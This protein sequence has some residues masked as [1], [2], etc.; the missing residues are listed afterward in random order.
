MSISRTAAVGAALIFVLPLCLTLRSFAQSAANT[1]C[2]ISGR[3]INRTT[4]D[5]VGNVSVKL[6]D[7][8]SLPDG[9]VSPWDGMV[10]N[11]GSSTTASSRYSVD[12][13]HDG[14]FCFA[15][16]APGQYRLFASKTGYLNSSYIED[17][18]IIEI[19]SGQEMLPPLSVN[20]APFSG[21]SGLVLDSAG[22][23]LMNVNMVAVKRSEIQGRV[24]LMPV[25][26]T[27]SSELG[28]FRIGKLVPGIYYVYAQP[29]PSGV[30]KSAVSLVRTYYPT[31]LTLAA[32][33]PITLGV[34]EEA[35]GVL[36]QVQ[37]AQIS[38]VVGRVLGPPDL[39]GGSTV[40]LHYADEDQLGILYGPNLSAE[41]MYDFPGVA[42]GRYL[43]TV[44]STRGGGHREVDVSSSDVTADVQ[45]VPNVTVSG[46]WV[47][48][49]TGAVGAAAMPRI[50]L[51]AADAVV[52]SSYVAA[53]YSDGTFS[54]PGVFPG[55]YFV[56]VSLANGTY[57]KQL[58]IG[59]K[60]SPTGE[61]DLTMGR[62]PE[63]K[64]EIAVGGSTLSGDITAM[65][66]AGA[67]SAPN[68]ARVVLMP[69]R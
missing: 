11:I 7:A 33:T 46:T 6:L 13:M 30:S 64:I 25:Q 21:I 55:R 19:S 50:D 51:T 58:R 53:V 31:S 15:A 62:S 60:E 45:F 32:S 35:S 42:P 61:V 43:L 63:I 39:W 40:N 34:G 26:G 2:A 48:Q 22:E 52:G 4:K 65:T 49:G 47:V 67:K 3:V 36:V 41:G 8:R 38:H 66:Q 10:G 54:A 69:R 59:N 44:R 27:Q 1:G 5:G 68:R 9:L 16:P 23:P 29:L 57:L 17:G 37:S 20:I 14:M 56:K 12:T 28:E 18:P 24:V